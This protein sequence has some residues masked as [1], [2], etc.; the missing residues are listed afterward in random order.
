MALGEQLD[1]EDAQKAKMTSGLRSCLYFS[2]DWL[3]R[4][5]ACMCDVIDWDLPFYTWYHSV[6]EPVSYSLNINSSLYHL[7]VHYNCNPEQIHSRC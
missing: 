7:A 6:T 5:G 1:V 2:C 4:V 3:L